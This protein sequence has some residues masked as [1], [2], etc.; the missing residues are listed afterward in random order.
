ML[1]QSVAAVV[2]HTSAQTRFC[3]PAAPENYDYVVWTYCANSA[4]QAA[5]AGCCSSQ[6]TKIFNL[7]QSLSS[8]GAENQRKA[9]T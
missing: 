3:W 7:V 2:C 8:G 4:A 6:Q 1:Q 5:Q 9:E